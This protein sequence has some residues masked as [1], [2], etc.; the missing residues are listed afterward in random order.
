[1]IKAAA[2]ATN[3]IRLWIT[4]LSNLHIQSNTCALLCLHQSHSSWEARKYFSSL[5]GWCRRIHC[6]R[7]IQNQFNRVAKPNQS[8]LLAEMWRRQTKATD[9][10]K[11]QAH[12][13]VGFL[14]NI[15]QT[16]ETI[17]F[18]AS[19]RSKNLWIHSQLIAQ[20]ALRT[21]IWIQQYEG[22]FILP[23]HARYFR[24]TQPSNDQFLSSSDVA[25][26][27]NQERTT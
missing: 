24:R 11:Y 21:A 3:S 1:M 18:L 5:I 9:Q 10:E 6:W 20:G 4:K 25:F 2:S 12:A 7:R 16:L 27:R 19:A 23:R 15:C 8:N 26:H 14:D 13:A 17:Q 22:C